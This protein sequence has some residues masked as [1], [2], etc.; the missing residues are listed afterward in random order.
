MQDTQNKLQHDKKQREKYPKSQ[1][2]SN[3]QAQTVNPTMLFYVA[4]LFTL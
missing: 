2:D 3:H 1:W 4:L